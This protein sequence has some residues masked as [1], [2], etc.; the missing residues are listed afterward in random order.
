[1]TLVLAY[2]CPAAIA[3]RQAFQAVPAWKDYLKANASLKARL[4]AVFGTVGLDAQAS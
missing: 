1:M 4:K 3:M 2:P